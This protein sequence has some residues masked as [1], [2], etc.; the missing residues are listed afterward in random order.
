MLGLEECD[1]VTGWIVHDELLAATGLI[2]F[3]V[4]V[5]VGGRTPGPAK[6]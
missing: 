2:G 6:S 4:T 5:L 3:A 1:G